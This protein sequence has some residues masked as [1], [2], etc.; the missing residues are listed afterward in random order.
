MRTATPV[1]PVGPTFTVFLN[2]DDDDSCHAFSSYRPG[3]HVADHEHPRWTRL[4]VV[5]RSRRRRGS[6]TSTRGCCTAAR[7]GPARV[8]VLRVRFAAVVK[9]GIEHLPGAQREH[10]VKVGIVVAEDHCLTHR[11]REDVR[12]ERLAQLI[13]H[14]WLARRMRRRRGTV[15]AL[16]PDDGAARTDRAPTAHSAR[17][18]HTVRL[19]MRQRAGPLGRRFRKGADR[20]LVGRDGA[21]RR[22]GAAPP[23]SS[24][25]TARAISGGRFGSLNSASH[26]RTARGVVSRLERDATAGHQVEDQVLPLDLR[27]ERQILRAADG[28]RYRHLAARRA[29]R[30][31]RSR[32]RRRRGA[33]A[34][35][36]ANETDGVGPPAT[37]IAISAARMTM[38]RPPTSGAAEGARP[39]V[40]HRRRKKTSRRGSDR[41]QE[42]NSRSI[43]ESRN[44]VG[45]ATTIEERSRAPRTVPKAGR[46]SAPSRPA[47]PMRTSRTGIAGSQI[48]SPGRCGPQSFGWARSVS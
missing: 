35:G 32:R 1:A 36:G 6:P 21:G 7:P 31:R 45:P 44:T 33:P 30:R 16:Q 12:Y 29:R 8:N 38:C 28:D 5:R 15:E 2:S 40:R 26:S 4:G 18:R 34:G 48:G 47:R 22:A 20:R 46:T 3:S 23:P 25:A 42:V 17:H 11:Y 41:S 13:E 14:A 19:R 24:G 39:L 10:V 43:R 37:M 9:T 27:L